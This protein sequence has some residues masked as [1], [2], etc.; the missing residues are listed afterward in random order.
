M[1]G[2]DSQYRFAP[3]GFGTAQGAGTGNVGQVE[4]TTKG[5]VGQIR[6]SA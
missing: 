2:Q 4:G 1:R 3:Y 6:Q 5:T